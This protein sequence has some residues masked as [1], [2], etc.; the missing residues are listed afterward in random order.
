MMLYHHI[1]VLIFLLA[2]EAAAAQH[3]QLLLRKNG[4]TKHRFREGSSIT[5]RTDKGLQYSG[6]IALLQNDSIYFDGSGIRVSEVKAIIRN[7][8][9]DKQVIPYPMDVFWYSNLGIPLLTA[10]LTLSGEPFLSSFLFGV[11]IVYMPIV[12]HNVLRIIR[13]RSR[14]Y[15]IG[16]TYD[17]RLLDLYRSEPL[18][19]KR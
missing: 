16:N 10:G 7:H 4:V 11:G 14:Q 15:N 8:R 13:N 3:N 17:L 5:I 19:E 1:F 9:K 6:T 2:A 18:P 12:G